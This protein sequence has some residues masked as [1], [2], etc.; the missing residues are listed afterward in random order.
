MKVTETKLAELKKGIATY[1]LMKQKG[2]NTRFFITKQ[3]HPEMRTHRIVTE[4]TLPA[5]MTHW[6]R[7]CY[8]RNTQ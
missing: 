1:C 4:E 8:D 3:E 5:V 6:E 2:H 7:I